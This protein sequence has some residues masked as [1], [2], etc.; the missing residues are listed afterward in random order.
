MPDQPL[1]PQTPLGQWLA[2]LFFNISQTLFKVGEFG[3]NLGL[4]SGGIASPAKP[5][6]EHFGE[7]HQLKK[8]HD[9]DNGGNDSNDFPHGISPPG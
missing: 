8:E 6:L 9:H 4:D 2:Q 5:I 7:I 1:S 3:I